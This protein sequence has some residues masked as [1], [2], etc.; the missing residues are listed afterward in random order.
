MTTEN[1]IEQFAALD[2]DVNET[3]INNWLNT[4]SPGYEHPSVQGIIELITILEKMLK[5][6]SNDTAHVKIQ[7]PLYLISNAEAMI[8]FYKFVPLS[9]RNTTYKYVYFKPPSTGKLDANRKQTKMDAFFFVINK[10]D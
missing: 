6:S 10:L 3:E 4:D 9:N 1:F 7:Q 2:I 5:S 8:I